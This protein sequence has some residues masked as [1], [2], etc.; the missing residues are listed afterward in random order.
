MRPLRLR[1]VL[2]VLVRRQQT[3]APVS[4]LLRQRGRPVT[5]IAN[6]H[7]TRRRR[8]LP[9]DLGFCGVSRGE[10]GGFNDAIAAGA[11]VQT[12]A[13]K[14]LA[15]DVILAEGGHAGEALAVGGAGELAG[16][17][18]HAIDVPQR[19]VRG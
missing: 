3:D 1:V 11:Q 8:Q 10:H 18:R 12:K 6:A 14:R 4:Q 13:V 5:A 17:H 7:A 9:D 15:N 16:M 2:L 19:V